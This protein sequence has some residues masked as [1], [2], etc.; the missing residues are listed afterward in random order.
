M[1]VLYASQA[2]AV[3]VG[4]IAYAFDRHRLA[5]GLAIWPIVVGVLIP[6]GYLLLG[7]G[8]GSR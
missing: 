5:A 1:V 6:L 8:S 3:L 2:A 4:W 7:A